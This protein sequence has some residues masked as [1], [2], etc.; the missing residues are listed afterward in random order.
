M[1]SNWKNAKSVAQ[2]DH[3]A[4]AL[5]RSQPKLFCRQGAVVAKWAVS[6]GRRVGP[7]YR[8]RFRLDGHDRSI[9]LGPEGPLVEEVR[10]RLARLHNALRENRRRQAWRREML[11][12]L[13]AD[14]KNLNCHLRSLGLTLKGSETRGWRNLRLT[15]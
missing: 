10:A 9:Y 4:V 12:Q 11:A 6:P 5:I 3:P 14:K 1:G 7:Y 13:R 2:H 15:P 8:L